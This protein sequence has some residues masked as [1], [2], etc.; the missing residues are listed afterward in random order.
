[1]TETSKSHRT[2]SEEDEDPNQIVT[3]FLLQPM[4]HLHIEKRSFVANSGYFSAMVTFNLSSCIAV[5]G[6]I[7]GFTLRK[8]FMV[9]YTFPIPSN[10]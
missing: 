8:E 3:A 5:F 6:R 1:M 2:R 7:N 9:D 4:Q 10:G